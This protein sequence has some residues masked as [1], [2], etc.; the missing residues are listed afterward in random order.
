MTTDEIERRLRYELWLGHGHGGPDLY[1]DDGEM[2][3][4][5][6]LP[7][8]RLWDYR[9]EPLEKVVEAAATARMVVFQERARAQAW[10]TDWPTEPGDY[11]FYGRLA[12]KADVRMDY[13]FVR[14]C[15]NGILR[16]VCG[17]PIDEGGASPATGRWR[18]IERPVPPTDG[19]T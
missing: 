18:R 4:S 19:P 7:L 11:W 5:A 10:S 13:G 1:G 6:C 9:R 3:C 17:V 8:S 15:A 12:P 14:R 16:I 2:Q